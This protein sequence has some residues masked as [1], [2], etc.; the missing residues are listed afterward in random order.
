M[1]SDVA[2]I[3]GWYGKLPTL[4]DFASRRLEGDFIEPWDLWLGECMQAQRDA[5]GEAWVEAYLHSPPWRFLLMPG[6]LPGF[7]PACMLAGVLTPSVDRVGR[8]FPL[9]IA[10]AVTRPPRSA[11]EFE[12]LLTWLHRLEDVAL[13]ALQDDWSIDELE[14]ALAPLAPPAGVAAGDDAGDHLAAIRA[15]LAE[16]M[17]GG[18]FVTIDAVASR[19]QLASLLCDAMPAGGGAPA[20]PRALAR[21]VAFWLADIPEQPRLLVSKG[22][23]DADDFVRM[24]SGGAGGA[25]TG[26]GAPGAPAAEAVEAYS[27]DT[28]APAVAEAPRVAAE[29]TDLLGMFEATA[30]TQGG[31]EHAREAL[32]HDDI[33]ALFGAD[34]PSHVEGLPESEAASDEGDIFAILDAPSGIGEIGDPGQ[35]GEIGDKGESGEKDEPHKPR[36]GL[37][38]APDILDLFG[39]PPADPGFGKRP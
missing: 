17:A 31:E 5:I 37:P 25:A 33:L 13:D 23:P 8:Y 18:G 21:G 1:A 20:A 39:G 29:A 4:G 2:S 24:F 32:P 16:A 15:R 12:P 36:D 7:D 10:A 14:D 22:L 28:L 30:G 38:A 27:F 35:I 6:V 26:A 11:V 34:V 9:T 19:A 3:P